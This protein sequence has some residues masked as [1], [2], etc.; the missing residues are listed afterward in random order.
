MHGRRD[1][2]RRQIVPPLA[3]THCTYISK[4]K[5]TV[6]PKTSTKMVLLT[7]KA[8][9]TRPHPQKIPPHTPKLNDFKLHTAAEV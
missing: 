2:A 7:P 6:N 4:N 3:G 1:P 9:P 8:T 5:I